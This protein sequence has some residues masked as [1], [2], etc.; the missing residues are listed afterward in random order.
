MIFNIAES[1]HSIQGEGT[2]SG[3]PAFFIRFAGCN[4]F[5]NC[6]CT[7]WNGV[8]FVCDT[9][10]KLNKVSLELFNLDEHVN[11]PEKYVIITGGEPFIQPHKLLIEIVKFFREQG[12]IICFETN[13]TSYIPS[14]IFQTCFVAC[15]PKHGYLAKQIPY[16]HELRL[17]TTEIL[18]TKNTPVEFQEHPNVFLSP[19]NFTNSPDSQALPLVLAS[20]QNFPHWRLSVQ[21]HKY[22]GVR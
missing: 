17:L 5:E 8:N 9:M 13:G 2:H 20:L 1:F 6:H 16:M 19:Y 18:D 11:I 12:K 22:L 21:L 14:Y 7:N 3:R 4:L 15:S 10:E